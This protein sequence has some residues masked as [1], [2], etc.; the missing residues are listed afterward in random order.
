MHWNKIEWV[1]LKK[2]INNNSSC[3]STNN[4]YIKYGKQACNFVGH[5]K[6]KPIDYVA[7]LKLQEKS[8]ALTASTASINVA[9]KKT[10]TTSFTSVKRRLMKHHVK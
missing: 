10:S 5:S 7:L 3:S 6:S 8:A 1:Y 2:N 9:Q 4:F